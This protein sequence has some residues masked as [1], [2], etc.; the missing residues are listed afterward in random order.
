MAGV[1]AGRRTKEPT[2][3]GVCGREATAIGISGRDKKLKPMW[4]CGLCSIKLAMKVA[5][6][7]PIKLEAAEIAA[8]EE[9]IRENMQD[10]VAAVMATLWEND[11][12][13][14]DAIT[15]ERFAPM[16]EKIY[17]GGDFKDA[18]VN[19]L[20]SYSNKVRLKLT[21]AK[22]EPKAEPKA[23]QPPEAEPSWQPA[24]RLNDDVV[25]EIDGVPF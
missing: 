10:I 17:A 13:D 24:P 25:S 16:V 15:A 5:Y 18:I 7:S 4:M 21:N 6:M 8:I 20:V 14:L 23:E 12:R 11:I 3:C 22:D 19:T 9:A 1:L 2:I